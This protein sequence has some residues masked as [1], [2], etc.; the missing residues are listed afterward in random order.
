[1]EV[2]RPVHLFEP[3][4][5]FSVTTNRGDSF[6]ERKWIIYI[7]SIEKMYDKDKVHYTMRYEHLRTD[8]FTATAYYREEFGTMIQSI[9]IFDP[10]DGAYVEL[11]ASDPIILGE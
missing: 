1:M 11:R 6:S 8:H 2:T 4:Q 7:D 10:Y 9:M 5:K 3:G